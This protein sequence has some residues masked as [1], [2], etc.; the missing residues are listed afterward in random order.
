M[1]KQNIPKI[2]IFIIII[3][4]II[5]FSGIGLG[6]LYSSLPEHHPEKNKEYCERAGGQWTTDGICLLSYKKAGEP[7]TDGGQCVSGICF[8]PTLTDEQK[9]NLARGPLKNII[10]TCYPEDLITDCVEQVIKGTISQQSL[11]PDD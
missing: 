3:F 4:A 8:P 1:Q 5:I 6:L 9:I 11:C 2:F 7:C 10:G